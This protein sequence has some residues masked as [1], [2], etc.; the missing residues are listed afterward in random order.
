MVSEYPSR[1]VM[2]RRKRME[3]LQ[4]RTTDASC[5]NFALE[6][7]CFYTGSEINPFEPALQVV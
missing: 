3:G 4:I 6:F 2:I 5:Q 7:Q 1:A